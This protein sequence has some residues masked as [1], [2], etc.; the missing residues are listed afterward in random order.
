LPGG[1]SGYIQDRLR[2]REEKRISPE[3]G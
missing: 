3:V 2:A 1:I